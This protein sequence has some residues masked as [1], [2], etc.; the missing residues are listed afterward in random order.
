MAAM[1]YTFKIIYEGCEDRIYRVAEVSSNSTLA[2]LGYVVLSSFDTMAYHLFEMTYNGTRYAL[3]A[4][5]FEFDD[6]DENYLFETK[7]SSLKMSVGEHIKM[8][9]DFGCD[10][11]FDIELTAVNEMKRGAGRRYPQIIDGAGRGI[12]DDM[13]AFELLELIHEIDEKGSCDV[14]YDKYG[15]GTRTWDYREYNIEYDKALLKGEVER[16]QYS[17]E[18]GE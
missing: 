14:V 18:D 9:Y 2:Q 8:I 17:Y 5:D 15:H 4:E 10:Q 6:D 16:I 11:M 3:D 7:L 12:I 13:P 1:V